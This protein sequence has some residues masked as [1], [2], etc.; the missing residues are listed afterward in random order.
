M[1][2]GHKIITNYNCLR[3]KC[4]SCSVKI[5]WMK[6]FEYWIWF[7]SLRTQELTIELLF[8]IHKLREWDIFIL[9]TSS[10]FPTTQ[11][12]NVL[13][14]RPTVFFCR[15]RAV[16]FKGWQIGSGTNIAT[17][18]QIT[19]KRYSWTFLKGRAWSDCGVF[20]DLIWYYTHM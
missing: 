1:C 10:T 14:K 7:S 20:I 11:C 6:I 13:G 19:E 9:S 15:T 8:E 2:D 4:F 5:T 12:N 17:K 18:V 16:S 3:S